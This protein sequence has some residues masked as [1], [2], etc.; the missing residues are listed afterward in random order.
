MKKLKSILSVV[1]AIL[2]VCSFNITAFAA[3][4][5]ASVVVNYLDDS[6]NPISSPKTFEKNVGDEYEVEIIEFENYQFS[7]AQGDLFGEV[8]AEGVEV[9]LVYK[10]RAEQGRVVVAF[11]DKEGNELADPMIMSGDVGSEWRAEPVEIE[12]YVPDNSKAVTG[13]YGQ[14]EINVV[15]TYSPVDVNQTYTIKTATHLTARSYSYN[16][17]DEAIY[18]KALH[19]NVGIPGAF[20]AGYYEPF[21]DVKINVCGKDFTEYGLN[22]E[23]YGLVLPVSLKEGECF[24]HHVEF[25]L[26]DGYTF[27]TIMIDEEKV[28]VKNLQYDAKTGTYSF[29]RVITNID[30]DG[31]SGLYVKVRER[32]TCTIDVQ[33]WDE[34]RCSIA[35]S[36]RITGPEGSTYSVTPPEIEGYTYVKALSDLNGTFTKGYDVV[37]LVYAQKAK[38]GSVTVKYLDENGKEIAEPTTVNG[39]IGDKWNISPKEIEGYVALSES[40]NGVFKENEVIEFQYAPK[41]PETVKITI[42]YVNEDMEN[43]AEP[44]VLEGKVGD[45]WKANPIDIDGYFFEEELGLSGTFEEEEEFFFVYEK[46]PDGALDDPEEPIVPEKPSVPDAPETPN[47]PSTPDKRDDIPKAEPTK[48]KDEPIKSDDKSPDTG[49]ALSFAPAICLIG[50]AVLLKKKK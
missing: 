20:G 44:L 2:I 45:T 34:N 10:L 11:V 23:R 6:G 3:G 16:P 28:S 38:T 19:S 39:N 8:P 24:T 7:G 46:S 43:L 12:G 40:A 29:D 5:I 42:Y 17:E 35:E 27:D 32:F 33:F 14:E 15:F 4:N 25:K 37:T 26:K 21:Y 31:I 47:I 1:L 22:P 9:N 13:I 49:A 18:L 48:T 30:E 41:A 36:K 50:A